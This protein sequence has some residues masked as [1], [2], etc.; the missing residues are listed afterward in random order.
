MHIETVTFSAVASQS[1]N[2]VF[3]ATYTNY[4]IL[5]TL[6]AVSNDTNVSLRLRTAG[7]DASGSNYNVAGLEL[8]VTA[9]GPNLYR[10]QNDTSA[11]FMNVDAGQSS[12]Y[13]STRFDMFN[14]FN[15]KRTTWLFQSMASTQAGTFASYTGGGNHTLETSFDSITFFPEAGTF[16]GT[17]SIFGYKD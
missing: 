17:I 4:Q 16:S 10:R 3:S 15:A 6:S 8:L 2:D 12:D 5:L 9:A 14:P 13:Y 1:I 11:F 7:S